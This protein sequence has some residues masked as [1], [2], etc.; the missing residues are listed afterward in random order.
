MAELYSR[1]LSA[2]GFSSSEKH[3][4]G[5]AHAH[6]DP[7]LITPDYLLGIN[8]L[9]QQ[10]LY[11]LY[12]D[13]VNA[14]VRALRKERIE[15]RRLQLSAAELARINA[16]VSFASHASLRTF[17]ETG[18][19]ADYQA[20]KFVTQGA[21]FLFAP[22]R[23]DHV[24][25]AIA[26][27]ME[28]PDDGGFFLIDRRGRICLYGSSGSLSVPVSYNPYRDFSVAILQNVAPEIPC[29]GFIDKHE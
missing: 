15:E 23:H 28:D 10:E 25:Y 8:G 14:A 19:R 3:R 4:R 16:D 17:Q 21:R 22:P 2:L 6:F 20:Y 9:R 5:A 29:V 7:A 26:A 13:V 11:I 24:N 12:P 27:G 1:I 18:P